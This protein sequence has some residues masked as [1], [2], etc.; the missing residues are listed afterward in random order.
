MNGAKIGD[1]PWGC[2]AFC[3]VMGFIAIMYLLIT[4]LIWLCNHIQI[5][6]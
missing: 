6:N 4:G 5:V 1:G 3:A 2:I